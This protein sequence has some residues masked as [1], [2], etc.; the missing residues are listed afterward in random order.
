[1]LSA[2]PLLDQQNRIQGCL[3][4]LVDVT[5]MKRAQE[6]LKKAHDELEV[7]VQE[8]T[9][10]LSETIKMLRETEKRLR[11]VSAQRLDAQE[12]ERKRIAGELHDSVAGM[13]SGIKF[14]VE[15]AILQI[16]K[17]TANPDL[18]KSLVP[19]IQEVVKETRRIIADLRPSTLDDLGLIAAI[20][21]QCHNFEETYS[22]IRVERKISLLETEV[23]VDL[24]IP[25]YRIVQEALNNIA[26][27]SKADLTNLS[28]RKMNNN[29]ELIIQDNGHGFDL[30]EV[31]SKESHG[32]GL[33]LDGITERAQ[34]SGGM[35][36]IESSIGNGTVVRASWPLT[37]GGR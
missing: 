30:Q 35:C 26:K 23:P 14:K 22:P 24:K 9:F 15:T 5:E 16:E 36:A 21:W 28:L 4:T 7:K 19:L 18:L 11:I 31:R 27:H 17:G 34:W 8:R 12:G 13:L 1:L 10:K 6:S 29:I 33:G 25:I 37:Q 3:V 20:N 2:R 32:R